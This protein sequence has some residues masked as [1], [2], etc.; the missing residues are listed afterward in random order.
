MHP[1]QQLL[2]SLEKDAEGLNTANHER[3]MQ[4]AAECLKRGGSPQDALILL[5]RMEKTPFAS[6]P[7]TSKA[8]SEVSSWLKPRVIQKDPPSAAELIWQ[9]GWLRRMARA[10]RELGRQRRGDG[11]PSEATSSSAS[12]SSATS[13]ASSSS[14]TS[15]SRDQRP[16][17]TRTG[18]PGLGSMAALLEGIKL[19]PSARKKG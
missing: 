17:E 8:L 7:D 13:S 3:F 9:L 12:S 2:Q 5:E 16:R 14:A 11:R 10:G 1:R 18:S 6:R 4:D 19:E 15:S